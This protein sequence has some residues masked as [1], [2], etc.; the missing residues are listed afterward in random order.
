VRAALQPNI[1]ENAAVE[2]ASVIAIMM[3]AMSFIKSPA[4][5]F[6]FLACPLALRASFAAVHCNV[7]ADECAPAA[8]LA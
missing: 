5:S 7:H 8:P 3:T 4:I 2:T 1:I 6:M